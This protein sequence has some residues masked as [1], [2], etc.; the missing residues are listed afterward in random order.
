[1]LGKLGVARNV[2]GALHATPGELQVLQAFKQFPF[3]VFRGLSFSPSAGPS[4][5]VTFRGVGPLSQP[6]PIVAQIPIPER[7]L[8]HPHSFPRIFASFATFCSNLFA[9]FCAKRGR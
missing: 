3:R 5:S 7:S 1:M 2:G 6:A 9:F 4:A 8:A